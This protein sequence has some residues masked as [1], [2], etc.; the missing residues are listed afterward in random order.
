[1]KD[2]QPGHCGWCRMKSSICTPRPHSRPSPSRSCYLSPAKVNNN[3]YQTS[4]S[5]IQITTWD[6]PR[7][8]IPRR[9]S[10]HQHPT[11]RE[12]TQLVAGMYPPPWIPV[13]RLRS[14]GMMTHPLASRRCQASRGKHQTMGPRVQKP[15][16][17]MTR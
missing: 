16:S 7:Q 14:C 6:H 3:T 4:V 9:P 2:H 12:I 15:S 1:M 8:L 13:T 17:Q 11:A 10:A 5:A